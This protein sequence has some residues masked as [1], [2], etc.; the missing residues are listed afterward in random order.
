MPD[1]HEARRILF[2]INS[3]A[4]GGAER[5][6]CKILENSGP[7]LDRY[8]PSVVL[9]DNDEEAYALPPSCT[10]HRL[11]CRHGF[12]RSLH[13]LSRFV[14]SERPDAAVA[15][16]TRA[17][18]A[19]IRAMRGIDHPVLISERVNTSAHLSTG[20]SAAVSRALVRHYYRRAD[21]I[22]G[23]SQGVNDCLIEDFGVPP[24]ITGVC[25]NPVDADHIRRLGREKPPIAMTP[26]DVVA[27]GRLVR[28]KN[29]TLAIDSF[30]RSG[31]PG[32][33]ILL[34]EGP[35]RAE[36][37]AH[38]RAVGLGDRV[39]LP[40]FQANPYA[41]MAAARQVLL[42]SDAEGFSNVLVEAMALSKPCVVT[43]CRSGPREILATPS[44]AP[45]TFVAGEGGLLCPT[46]DAAAL[47]DALRALQDPALYAALSKKAC[48][49]VRAFSVDACVQT[50]WKAIDALPF[51]ESLSS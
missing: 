27:V 16:L 4:G 42:T 1:Q 3:L 6:F 49:R 26:G 43:D 38:A 34:G 13:R 11:D 23:V 50:F 32:R 39:L 30:A 10:V 47:A 41:F 17:N 19:A 5:V 24:S 48:D 14:R 22:L 9:L 37:E 12:L 15:F 18:I 44:P 28:N 45:G 40:G 20:K 2:V 33:L 29:F 25:Y 36:L 21:F 31:L 8:R 51:R 46:G 7:W 35:L